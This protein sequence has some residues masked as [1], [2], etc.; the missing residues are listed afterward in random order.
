MLDLIKLT[1]ARQT[2]DGLALRVN[3]VARV[4]DAVGRLLKEERMHNLIPTVGLEHVAALLEDATA[5]TEMG[6]GGVGTGTTPAAAGDTA[7]E[8]PL[9]SR[10]A[11]TSRVRSGAQTTYTFSVTGLTGAVTETIIAND[12]SAGDILARVVHGA[13]NLTPSVT[14][15]YDWTVTVADDGV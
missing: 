13:F 2:R 7:L 10:V 5:V 3:V 9:G 15:T 12:P 4:Y 8:T 1:G 14:L 11:L 6:Y